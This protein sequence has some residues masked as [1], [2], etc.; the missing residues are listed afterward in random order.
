VLKICAHLGK[1]SGLFAILGHRF[2]AARIRSA[3][4]RHGPWWDR[5]AWTASEMRSSGNPWARDRA[6]GVGRGGGQRRS[7]QSFGEDDGNE[8]RERERDQICRHPPASSNDK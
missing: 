7:G 1:G 2:P 3:P 5:V 8:A 6:L 4:C